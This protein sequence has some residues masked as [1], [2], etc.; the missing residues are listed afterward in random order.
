MNELKYERSSRRAD[1][2]GLH[3]ARVSAGG[4][5]VDTSV[6]KIASRDS[7]T[8]RS[9]CRRHP[10]G[11]MAAASAGRRSWSFVV[12]T[13][14]ART[15]PQRCRYDSTFCTPGMPARQLM[16]VV[17]R[18]FHLDVD[19]RALCRR[20]WL[21]F[22]G[23][24]TATIRPRLMMMMRSQVASTSDRMWVE[25]ITVRSP[26][27]WRTRRA[28]LRDLLG[29]E[30]RGRL[31]QDQD[32]RRSE[33]RPARCRRAGD[34]PSRACPPDVGPR[35]RRRRL[36]RLGDAAPPLAG[37]DPLHLP[38]VLEVLPH[39]HVEVE[40]DTLREVAH[41]A[42]GAQRFLG[43]V[44]SRHHRLARRRRKDP[45]QDPHCRALPG[46][47][48]AEETDDLAALHLEGHVLDRSEGAEALGE[49]LR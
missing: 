36:H 46:S 38:G 4:A 2:E 13:V 43:H 44:V 20:R 21:R 22:C 48:G 15:P 11:V 10:L 7:V 23:V 37:R 30:A 47:V 42:A 28:H 40:R 33:E 18:T 31:V 5:V 32:A 16:D 6:R 39:R 9:S 25:R 8:A 1:G 49:M 45:G 26:R 19:L 14:S 29:I 34:T 12:E 27:S 24:S 17:L 41:D 3:D 35:A